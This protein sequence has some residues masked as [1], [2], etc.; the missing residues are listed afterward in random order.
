M[1]SISL[2]IPQIR[3]FRPFLPARNYQ[4]SLRFY[5]TL[6]FDVYPLGDGLAEVSLGTHAFLLQNQYLK[7]WADNTV[8]HILV[9]DVRA[10]W[11]HIDSLDLA[12]HFGVQTPVAPRVEPWGLAVAYVFDP[13]G[14]LWHFAQDS[15]SYEKHL[16][17]EA[18]SR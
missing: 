5:K 8:M 7:Q 15:E 17:E 6:G 9:E 1:N 10:W 14:L 12:K 18:A 4:T 2:L 13:A 11:R 3:A 16:A